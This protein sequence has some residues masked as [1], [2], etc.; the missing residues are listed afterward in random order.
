MHKPTNDKS[1]V[2]MILKHL[3]DA[4]WELTSVYDSEE[5]YPVQNDVQTA[6]GH[7]MD[8]DDSTVLMARDGESACVWF[9]LG[10]SPEEAPADYSTNLEPDLGWLLDQW[11]Q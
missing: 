8:V 5:S 1:A 6:L 4:G 11:M 9:V 2:T 7:V 10:N 3:K